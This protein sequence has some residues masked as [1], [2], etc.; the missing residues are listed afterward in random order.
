[1]IIY[2]IKGSSTIRDE[3]DRIM[4]NIINKEKLLKEQ[5]NK[6]QQ[7]NNN[8][9]INVK[10]K[11]IKIYK[12]KNKNSSE[13]KLFDSSNKFTSK[14]SN[15][16]IQGTK[17][18]LNSNKKLIKCNKKINIKRKRKEKNSEPPK[19]FKNLNKKIVNFSCKEN[20]S[21]ASS[22]YTSKKILKVTNKSSKSD[23][24]IIQNNYF[25]KNNKQ[26]YNN[27]FNKKLEKSN[28]NLPNK[29]INTKKIVQYLNDEELNS[30]EYKKACEIDKRT[31]FQYYRSLLM[32]KQL[33]LFT[34]VSSNDY[35]LKILKISLFLISFSLYFTINGFFFSDSTMH[36]IFEDKGKYNLLYEIPQIIYSS[37]VS[38]IINMI[39][40]QLYLSEKDMIKIKKEKNIQIANKKIKE[41]NKCLLIKFAIFHVLGFLFMIFFWYFITCFCCIYKN[42]QNILIQNTLMSFCLSMLYPFGLNLLPGFFRIPALKDKNKNKVCMYKLSGIIALI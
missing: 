23:K 30:L 9:N 18:N 38:A 1:M 24:K 35:N 32:K 34:F 15:S 10:F 26:M 5:K 2:C 3:L 27:V 21:L 19:K 20:E 7:N 13:N 39:L 40:K 37:G 31:Y 28:K 29:I 36:K 33:I 4:K 25:I 17:M 22:Q 8:N 11:E 16:L 41:V 6:N 42:T 12:N 14:S